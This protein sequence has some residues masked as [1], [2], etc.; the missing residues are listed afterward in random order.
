MSQE[1]ATQAKENY[2]EEKIVLPD[3]QCYIAKNP[4]A[5]MC[6]E[7]AT[8]KTAFAIFEKKFNA[9]NEKD[10]CVG[11]CNARGTVSRVNGWL[12]HKGFAII[13]PTRMT[14]EGRPETDYW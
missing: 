10:M 2:I 1:R 5:K 8:A 7:M 13:F 9:L 11:H 12:R 4:K 6:L 14:E 3:G